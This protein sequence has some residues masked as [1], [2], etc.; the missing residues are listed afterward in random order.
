MATGKIKEI[1]QGQDHVAAQTRRDNWEVMKPFVRFSFGAIK[2]IGLGLLAIV[3]A[4]P[5]LKHDDDSKKKPTRT[6]IVK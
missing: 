6:I 4:L 3:K 2:I 1:N 5:A